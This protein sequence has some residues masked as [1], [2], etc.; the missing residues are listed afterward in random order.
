ML[1]A[2]GSAA[3]TA[4]RRRALRISRRLR[5]RAEEKR[6]SARSI[7]AYYC[8]GSKADPASVL[9]GSGAHENSN[10]TIVLP[11]HRC[12]CLPANTTPVRR[13]SGEGDRATGLTPMIRIVAKH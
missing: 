7:S 2:I 5:R 8:A 11:M 13:G 12:R 9:A 6:S 10:G 3:S 4:R 1:S